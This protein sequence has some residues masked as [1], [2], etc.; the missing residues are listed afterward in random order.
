MS[1]P[2]RFVS[3][4]YSTPCTR[5]AWLGD[6][7]IATVGLY[8]ARKVVAFTKAVLKG[9]KEAPKD[10]AAESS[11]AMNVATKDNDND[12]DQDQGDDEKVCSYMYVV[13]MLYFSI[14]LR[15]NGPRCV[16]FS[17]CRSRGRVSS[18]RVCTAVSCTA[19]L[20][21][22]P[23]LP[24]RTWGDRSTDAGVLSSFAGGWVGA[25]S[26]AVLGRVRFQQLLRDS[27]C[28]ARRFGSDFP[29]S[30]YRMMH[31]ASSVEVVVHHLDYPCPSFCL[32][33]VLA[34]GML[35]SPSAFFSLG[36]PAARIASHLIASWPVALPRCLG[37]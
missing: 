27:C 34:I 29:G 28:V 23:S 8:G 18:C 14:Y 37:C 24:Q 30:K 19:V 20:Y 36:V 17:F 11:A 26:I 16:M 9:R 33:F 7:K 6:G 32:V 1:H 10:E 15:G 31:D 3:G 25:S 35:Q 22:A 12:D 4:P 2:P 5:L 13:C 21:V